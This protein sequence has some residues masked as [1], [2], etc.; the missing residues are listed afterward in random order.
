MERFF[1]KPPKD[2]DNENVARNSSGITSTSR[3]TRVHRRCPDLL[4]RP[5]RTAHAPTTHRGSSGSRARDAP[6]LRAW[7]CWGVR[8][9][10]HSPSSAAIPL[11]AAPRLASPGRKTDRAEALSAAPVAV[12][13]ASAAAAVP[14]PSGAS[15][16]ELQREQRDFGLQ[17]VH[18]ALERIDQPR[19]LVERRLCTRVELAGW[20]G[21]G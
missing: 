19:R 3:L 14:V 18:L 2:T 11:A 7:C 21:W 20:E 6:P 5:C 13:A 9:S 16:V 15:V 17:P 8:S 4:R 12:P 1:L 10:V